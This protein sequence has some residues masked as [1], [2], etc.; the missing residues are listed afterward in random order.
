MAQVPLMTPVV[1][2]DTPSRATLPSPVQARFVRPTGSGPTPRERH[3]VTQT[4]DGEIRQLGTWVNDPV[5][6]PLGLAFASLA[7]AL[8]RAGR[9]DE[10]LSCVDGGLAKH[11]DFASAHLVRGRIADDRGDLQTARSA[12]ERVLELDAHNR[13]APAALRRIEERE[14]NTAGPVLLASSPEQPGGSPRGVGPLQSSG[15]SQRS[16]LAETPEGTAQTPPTE[17]SPAPLSAAEFAAMAGGQPSRPAE[18]AP[19][20]RPPLATRTL[21]ETYARQGLYEQAVE[22][23]EQVL[24][25]TPNDDELRARIAELRQGR[26]GATSSARPA[27]AGA[28]LPGAEPPAAAVSDTEPLADAGPPIDPL[29]AAPDVADEPSVRDYFSRLQAFTPADRGQSDR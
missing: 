4:I 15:P 24:E 26:G 8:R 13:F 17:R 14:A 18:P 9:L 10:A 12:Y 3:G 23:L 29:M 1:R 20:T 28:R 27:P 11:P 2:V 21:A 25:G 19:G 22:V 16:D 6:D 7:D 5:R